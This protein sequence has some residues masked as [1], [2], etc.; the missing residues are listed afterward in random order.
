MV[1]GG[2]DEEWERHLQGS[3]DPDERIYRTFS[4]EPVQ[5]ATHRAVYRRGD[6]PVTPPVREVCQRQRKARLKRQETTHRSNRH[7][8]GNLPAARAAYRRVLAAA[9]GA[10]PVEEQQRRK[11]LEGFLQ[12]A[13]PPA[14]CWR[15]L[16][17][18]G[19]PPV[20]ML[21]TRLDLWEKVRFTKRQRR[22]LA[23][24]GLAGELV[25]HVNSPE[26][27]AY[28]EEVLAAQ[29]R[30]EPM[31]RVEIP[32]ECGAGGAR[33]D[34]RWLRR[35][36]ESCLLRKAGAQLSLCGRCRRYV[37]VIRDVS[38]RCPAHSPA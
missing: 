28:R 12:F 2:R 11:D 13:H 26:G 38:A 6:V 1:P 32:L 3:R 23:A 18:R 22:S 35:Y 14:K 27:A 4:D 30:G 5:L 8:K 25:R 31:P 24:I 20:E 16:A 37:F 19:V 10:F 34:P 21:F 15:Q 29:T 36:N 33:E 7:L 17:Q 9:W